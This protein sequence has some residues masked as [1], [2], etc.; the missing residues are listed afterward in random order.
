[1][2]NVSTRIQ[3]V[4][5]PS[6]IPHYPNTLFQ[7]QLYLYD[8]IALSG[9]LAWALEVS[10]LRQLHFFV[11]FIPFINKDVITDLAKI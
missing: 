4:F 6:E 7:Q 1:M 5:A 3:P 2:A 10:H 8:N 9:D 11:S